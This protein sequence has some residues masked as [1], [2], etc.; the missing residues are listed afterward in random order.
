MNK[1]YISPD[2][3]RLDSFRLAKKVQDSGWIP[4]YM[5]ALWRGGAPIGCCIHEFFKWHGHNV[6]HVAIRTSRYTGI[7]EAEEQVQVHSLSYLIGALR[8]GTNGA[9]VT[10]VTNGADA[11][12]R[13]LLV[14]DVWDSGTT[15]KAFLD[16]LSKELGGG[17]VDVR[18]ATVYYK[19]TKNKLSRTPD[20]FIHETDEWLVFPH[21]LEGMTVEEVNEVMGTNVGRLLSPSGI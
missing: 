14:D 2:N 5:V 17:A 19:P 20:Y 8:A 1:C 21:E 9:S 16:A 11:A 3:L 6:D 7:G 4:N 10:S 12:P 13:V 15:I 18:V